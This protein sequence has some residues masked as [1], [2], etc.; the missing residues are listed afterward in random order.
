VLT[1]HEAAGERKLALL[2]IIPGNIFIP[3]VC[4]YV[5]QHLLSPPLKSMALLL[6]DVLNQP[7][8]PVKRTFDAALMALPV[9]DA[10]TMPTFDS[11]KSV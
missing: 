3:I 10:A 5:T 11:V 2:T 7:T 6:A 8:L 9:Q 4:F 1:A